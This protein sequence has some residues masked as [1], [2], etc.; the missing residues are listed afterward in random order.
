MFENLTADQQTVVNNFIEAMFP[1]APT[2]Y[3]LE[4]TQHQRRRA[5]CPVWTVEE[6]LAREG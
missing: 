5:V 6:I 4:N 3:V 1:P 2:S